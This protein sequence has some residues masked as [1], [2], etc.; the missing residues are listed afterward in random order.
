MRTFK[1]LMKAIHQEDK[2]IVRG[3]WK[4]F[5]IMYVVNNIV[6]SWNLVKSTLVFGTVDGQSVIVMLQVFL[7]QKVYFEIG[8][9]L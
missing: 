4:K 5:N 7:E 1:K 2:P 6:V 3:F 8:K 9:I